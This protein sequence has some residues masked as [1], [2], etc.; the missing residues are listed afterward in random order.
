MW[1]RWLRSL[2]RGGRSWGRD[3]CPSSLTSRPRWGRIHANTEQARLLRVRSSWESSF[4][5]AV[6]DQG[7]RLHGHRRYRPTNATGLP[8]RAGGGRSAPTHRAD[9]G[10]RAGLEPGA[11][12]GKK[13]NG[14]SQRTRS[15]LLLTSV[16]V[17]P[18]LLVQS[19]ETDCFTNLPEQVR[20]WTHHFITGKS[21]LVWLLLVSQDGFWYQVWT[22]S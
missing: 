22:G 15:D 17:S 18:W 8:E 4:S 12:D 7:V 14:L 10:Q 11:E 6:R 1:P 2:G 20:A 16:W 19:A 13:K 9:H 5:G 21:L 3:W